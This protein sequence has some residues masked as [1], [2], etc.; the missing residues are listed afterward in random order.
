MV[1][2]VTRAGFSIPEKVTINPTSAGIEEPTRW[3]AA[4]R[5]LGRRNREGEGRR[6]GRAG[7]AEGDRPAE[8]PRARW[9]GALWEVV[10]TLSLG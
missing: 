7:V 9:R 2:S 6:W 1:S 3:L 8:G 4:G 10:R 5:V